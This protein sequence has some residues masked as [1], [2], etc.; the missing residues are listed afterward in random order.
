MTDVLM[1]DDQR[2]G[3]AVRVRGPKLAEAVV[4]EQYR[5]QPDLAERYGPN[6][7]RCC[8]RDVGH[9]VEFLAASIELADPERFVSYVRWARGVMAA[10]GVPAGDFLVS[11]RALRS[12]VVELLPPGPAEIAGRHVDAALRAWDEACPN[13]RQAS[14]AHHGANETND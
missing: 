10:H 5:L 8:V 13:A 14:E 6:G 4:A 1:S 11:L 7:R 3:H 2:A 9:H 12:V